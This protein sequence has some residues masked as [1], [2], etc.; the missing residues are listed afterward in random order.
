MT[1]PG[2]PTRATDSRFT[3][4]RL[5]CQINM[6]AGTEYPLAAQE[7]IR[8][9]AQREL[10]AVCTEVLDHL[11][12]DG[13]AVYRIR[14]L[15]LELWI[16]QGMS[17]ADIAGRWGRLLAGSTARTMVRGDPGQVMRF[18]SA[19][20]LVACFLRDLIDG[21]A[22]HQWYYDEFR[23]LERLPLSRLALELLAPRP[24]WIAP[25]LLTLSATGHSERLIEGWGEADIDALWQALGFP[26]APVAAL[27]DGETLPGALARVWRRTA[28]S[29]GTDGAAR[30]R[31][32][33]R[34][35][36]ALANHDPAHAQDARAAGVL[37]AMV[38]LAVLLRSEP[39]LA[40]LL[41][42]ESEPYPALLKRL[43][44]GPMTKV[45]GWLVETAA[46]APGR[47]MLRQMIEAIESRDGGRAF[48]RSRRPDETTGARDRAPT[49]ALASSVGS[50]FLLVPALAETGLWQLWLDEGSEETARRYLFAVA[51][52]ALGRER[53]PLHLGDPLL[54]ALAGLDEPPVADLRSPPNPDAPAGEWARCLPAIAEKWHPA[55]E[56]RLQ[57]A[58]LTDIGIVRDQTAAC[59][60][61]AWPNKALQTGDI[62]ERWREMTA[63][64]SEIRCELDESERETIEAEARHLQLGPRLGYSWLTPTLDAALSVVTSLVMRRTA[65]RLPRFGQTSPA[66]LARQFLAQP[67][68]LRTTPEAWSVQL[69]GGPL[70]VVL[71]MASLLQVVEAPWLPL[72]LRMTLSTRIGM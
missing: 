55:R 30:A 37:Q 13:D 19:Q 11:Q 10:A 32:R 17:E 51:L 66:Y 52:K 46:H 42:M 56:R 60:L 47:R 1:D 35:W 50:A 45:V 15:R 67:A 71:R 38:D 21:R 36:L 9:A 20:H 62:F 63:D 31:D 26:R 7:R 28:L 2:L 69:S 39:E 54:A 43:A 4:E 24:Q 29:G 22:W 58:I 6:P 49:A 40:P 12:E 41:L 44:G 64:R 23:L 27:R 16:D 25:I 34:L 57:A 72:P 33:L 8:R 70:A 61:A 53:A 18:D 5:T 59:W 68:S 14:S 48:R 3:V 65:A